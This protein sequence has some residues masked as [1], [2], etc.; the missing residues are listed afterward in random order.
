M[1]AVPEPPGEAELCAYVDGHLPAGRVPAVEAWLAAD[2]VDRARVA[3]WRRQN[4]LMM[5]LYDGGAD[6]P[7]PARLRP[8]RLVEEQRRLLRRIAVAALV[9]LIIGTGAGWVARDLVLASAEPADAI[10]REGIRWHRLASG[11]PPAGLAE[12]DRRRLSEQLSQTLDHPVPIP[13]LARL[14]L[15]LLGGRAL[16]TAAGEAAAQLSY[17]DASGIR[18]TLYLVQPRPLGIADLRRIEAEGVNAFSWPYEEFRCVLVGDAPPDR[19]LGIA[20][21]VQAQIDIADPPEG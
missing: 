17:E 10:A 21:A 20:R 7:L 9:A 18:F 12:S 5:R 2:A 11:E 16:P 15:R 19:L 4:E 3:A 6:D 14:G 13:D 8:M 1:S